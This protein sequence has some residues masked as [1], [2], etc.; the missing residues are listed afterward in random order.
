MFYTPA[1]ANPAGSEHMRTFVQQELDK[2]AN[3]FGRLADSVFGA[4]V[5]L[6][7]SNALFTRGRVITAGANVTVSTATPGQV[8]ISSSGGGGGGGGYGY[9]PGGWG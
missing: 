4:P 3:A 1:R 8:V 9:M 2:I 7:A 6:T 5:A